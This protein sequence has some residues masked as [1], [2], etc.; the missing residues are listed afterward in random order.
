MDKQTFLLNSEQRLIEKRALQLYDASEQRAGHPIYL[1]D[2]NHQCDSRCS[3]CEIKGMKCFVCINS[4]S[5]HVCGSKCK[6]QN[7][8]GVCELTGF[9]VQLQQI[10]YHP[11]FSNADPRVKLHDITCRLP[12]GRR[13]KRRPIVLTFNKKVVLIK[14]CIVKIMCGKE[15]NVSYRKELERY[16]RDVR[17]S[18]KR[19][20]KP[21]IFPISQVIAA[22]LY[23][24]RG[25]MLYPPCSLLS[26]GDVTKLSERLCR[27]NELISTY[28]SEL[29]LLC[30]NLD[31]FTACMVYRLAVGSVYDDITFITPEE[32][33]ISHVPHESQFGELGIPCNAMARMSRKIQESC[34]SSN[35]HVNIR[36]IFPRV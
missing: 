14:A 13:S 12:T 32:P 19:E 28:N 29:Q 30:Q 34:L 35:R 4:R 7:Y 5:V 27:Y 3:L 36:M 18:L 31:V 9:V 8:E 21:L 22:S 11:I 16:E 6:R 10:I 20:K 26:L 24:K 15:R 25:R 2:R 23:T 1:P 33:F 17:D